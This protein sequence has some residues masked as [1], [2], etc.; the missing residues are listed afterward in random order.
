MRNIHGWQ[1]SVAFTDAYTDK[2]QDQAGFV[3]PTGAIFA[4]AGEMKWINE[5][6]PNPDT[7]S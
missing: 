1:Q 3:I 5:M 4:T 2:Q 6:K 7:G